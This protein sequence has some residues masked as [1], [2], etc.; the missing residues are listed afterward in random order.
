MPRRRRRARSA[1]PSASPCRSAA[2]SPSPTRSTDPLADL[3]ARFARTHGRSSPRTSPGAS[4]SPPSG[5]SPCSTGSRPRAGWSGASSGPTASSASGATAMC[6]GSSGGAR[7]RRCEA[8]SSRSTPAAWPASCP[9]GRASGVPRR[10]LDALVEVHR[11]AAGRGAAGVRRSR[12]TSCRPDWRATRRPTSTRCAPRA[13]SC[14]WAP[15]RSARTDGRVRLLFRDQ[16]G[17][18]SFPA[19]APAL[20]PPEGAVHDALRAQLTD[21]GASFWPDLVA[22]RPS[23]RQPY[24]DATVLAAL[25]DLVWA[26]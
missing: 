20:E 24:D 26:G 13:R 11:R 6:C 3:V 19:S 4:V 14:G 10:G 25:W 8:R 21:R 18:C 22:R 12:A 9:R 7:W 1:T 2:R 17:R 23:G 5:S 15:A 16:V